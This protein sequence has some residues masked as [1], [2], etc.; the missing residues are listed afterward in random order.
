VTKLSDSLGNVTARINSGTVPTSV[1]IRAVLHTPNGDVSTVSSALAVAVG[2]PSQ[3]NFSLSQGTFNIEGYNT[4]GTPNTYQIIAADRLGNPVPDGTSINYITEGGQVEAIKFTQVGSD[5]I[6]RA[7]ANF[8]SSEPRP[9]DGRVTVLA[10]A[11]GEESFLDTNGNNVF[12]SGE[13]YQDLGNVYLDRAFDGNYNAAL[14]QLIP[15]SIS[16]TDIC[17][18]P[19]PS[20]ASL[21]NKG[22]TIPSV[23]G[24]CVTGWGRA[25]VR[26]SIETIL[27]T[28]VAR[29]RWASKNP[30]QFQ[31]GNSCKT[32][33]LLTVD[34]SHPPSDDAKNDINDLTKTTL[35]YDVGGSSLF[36][37][38]I[39]GVISFYASDANA[40]RLNPVAAGTT[41]SVETTDGLSAS[42]VGG[43]PVP[44]TLEATFVSIKYKFEPTASSGVVTIKITSPGGLETAVPLNV[45]V[46]APGAGVGP[47]P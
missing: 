16:G 2:L 4:D 41:V 9:L 10:Y 28:S 3:L 37:L 32:Q 17:H 14:D 44:S 33:R 26:R 8:V 30:N 35:Y 42:V 7:V 36:N 22:R 31:T 43:S 34:D 46:G 19:D 6:A 38:G 45:N 20:S 24:T 29:P 39:S 12:D 47:C 5:G 13:D 40:Y 23:P 18:D 11:L 21:L 27:S 15:L 1:R 25:Y